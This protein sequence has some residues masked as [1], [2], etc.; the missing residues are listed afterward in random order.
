VRWLLR[1]NRRYDEARERYAPFDS[2]REPDPESR[3]D[4]AKAVAAALGEQR[5]VFVIANNKAEGSAPLT[6]IELARELA[7][8]SSTRPRAPR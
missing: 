5:P 2:L 1:R 8:I 7:V 4:L 6:L 3:Y